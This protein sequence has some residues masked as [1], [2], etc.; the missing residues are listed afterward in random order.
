M[1]AMMGSLRAQPGRAAFEVL[2]AQVALRRSFRAR[3]S[4]DSARAAAAN[5]VPVATGYPQRNGP[6]LLS[7]YGVPHL[8][9]DPHS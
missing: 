8:T 2:A 4:L 1:I 7:G 6:L 5:Q 9:A 3:S